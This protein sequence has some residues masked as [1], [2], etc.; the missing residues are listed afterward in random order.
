[1]HNSLTHA[2]LDDNAKH[3]LDVRHVATAFLNYLDSGH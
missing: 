1:M 3:R 2:L